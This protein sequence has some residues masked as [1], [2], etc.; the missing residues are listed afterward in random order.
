[1]TRE[2]FEKA[3]LDALL[4]YMSAAEHD[5]SISKTERQKRNALNRIKL[6]KNGLEKINS[7]NFWDSFTEC[8]FS[9]VYQFYDDDWEVSPF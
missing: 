2:N 8:V 4:R 1:M 3:R 6:C 5:F 7:G 9:N